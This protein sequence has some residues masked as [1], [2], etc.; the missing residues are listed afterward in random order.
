MQINSVSAVS[1]A[2][3]APEL[4]GVAGGEAG[5]NDFMLLLLAQMTHQNPL[6]PLKDSEM[7]SQYAQLNSVQQLQSINSALSQMMAFNQT[8]YA[9]S[10]IGK[11]AKV[12]K[13]DGN[14]LEGEV[15]G[16][17]VESGK[18]YIQIGEEKAPLSNVVEIKGG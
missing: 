16:V 13:D 18:I 1:M 14:T 4:Q 12:A 11:V 6:E 2:N 7:M 10:L 17:T 15:S 5:S 9:A 3:S 8:S